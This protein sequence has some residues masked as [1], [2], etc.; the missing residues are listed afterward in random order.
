MKHKSQPCDREGLRRLLDE[1]VSDR[2][3]EELVAHLDECEPCRLAL[4]GLAAG[5]EWWADA[6]QFVGRQGETGDCPGAA[7]GVGAPDQPGVFRKD[8]EPTVRDEVDLEFLA[9]SD[10]PGSLGRLG[11]YEIKGILGRGGMGIVLCAHDPAL[12]RQVA[13]KVLAPGLHAGALAR[14]RFA[15]EARAAAAVVNEH[16]VAIHAV[17]E[18]EGLPYLVMQYVA[19]KSLQE[20]IDRGGPLRTEEILRIGMQAA[21]GLA[22]AHAQGLVHRD[23]KPANIL[24]ENGVERV[25]LTDFGLARAVDDCSLTHQGVV[26]GTPQY[27]APEQARGESVDH[28]ADLFSLGGVLYAMCTGRPPFRADSTPAVLRQICDEHPKS[29]RH[30]NREVPDWLAAVIERLHSKA[31]AHR[32][33]SAVEV[34]EILGSGLARLQESVRAAEDVGQPRPE[35]V[36]PGLAGRRN[37]VILLMLLGLSGVGAAV[38]LAHLAQMGP[39]AASGERSVPS[40][41]EAQE[42]PSPAPSLT[43]LEARSPVGPARSISGGVRDRQTGKVV[44]GVRLSLPGTSAVATT[45]AE[46]RYGLRGPANSRAPDGF[47]PGTFDVLVEPG[48]KLYFSSS[49]RIEGGEGSEPIGADINLSTGIPFRL[50]LTDEASGGPV[51]KA[52]V[53]YRPLHPNPHVDGALARGGSG[54]YCPAAEG[55][56]GSY[57]GVMLAGPGAICVESYTD[58]YGPVSVDPVAFFVPG[59]TAGRS[60][61]G[62]T[63]YGNT[64]VLAL[65]MGD[66]HGIH[67]L[68]QDGMSGLLLVDPRVGDR[69]DEIQLSLHDN[70]L[71]KAPP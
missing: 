31:P 53:V 36:T 52:R 34:A 48:A 47:A 13:I 27:M 1:G 9:P 7:F 54:L 71:R 21:T 22:A 23:V 18:W 69:P 59:K 56:D 49:V 10:T 65:E 3:R 62:S 50:R 6:K 33:Q 8:D 43:S 51:R 41:V 35:I 2:R 63:G 25:K 4:E 14:R 61:D 37:T 39:P 11:P 5:G 58:Y 44:P 16:V 24:L 64:Q 28:R 32:Y 45:D 68:P 30:E 60:W 40:S 29:V 66:G 19:G 38:S 20:R 17:D 26:A 46:G 70:R 12:D 15:R 67:L 55:P 42:I 57:T